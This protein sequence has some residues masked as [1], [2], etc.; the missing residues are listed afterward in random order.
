MTQTPR[1]PRPTRPK[2]LPKTVQPFRPQ[3]GDQVVLRT[4][5]E[6]VGTVRESDE[7]WDTLLLRGVDIADQALVEWAWTRSWE[8]VSQLDP[9]P[10]TEVKGDDQ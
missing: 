3:P 5:P 8:R 7:W 4:D 6:T 2:P 9:A 1:P 10:T